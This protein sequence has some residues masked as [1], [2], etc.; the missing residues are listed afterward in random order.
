MSLVT[1][2]SNTQHVT[3]HLKSSEDPTKEARRD[4][5]V[6]RRPPQYSGKSSS[7]RGVRGAINKYIN[8]K[9]KYIDM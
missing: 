8:N 6:L 5:E 3:E 1:R 4:T 9:K 7:S 2:L